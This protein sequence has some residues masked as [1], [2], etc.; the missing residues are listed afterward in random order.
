MHS[1]GNPNQD[2][3]ENSRRNA[4]LQIRAG[5]SDEFSQLAA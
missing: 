1:H 4:A 2:V 3:G 5:S